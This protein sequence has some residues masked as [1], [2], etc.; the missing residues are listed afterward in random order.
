MRKMI[1][2]FL[3]CFFPVT[4][5]VLA[6]SDADRIKALEDKVE[7]LT[8]QLGLDKVDSTEEASAPKMTLKEKYDEKI[9]KVKSKIPFEISGS[10]DVYVQTNF[11]GKQTNAV[12]HRAF[13]PKANSFELGMIN[14]IMKKKVKKVGFVADI[15][16]GPRAEAANNTIYS[17]TILAIK[18]LYMTYAPAD[19]VEFTLGNFSTFFGYELI[20]PQNNFNYSTSL[21]FENGPFYHTGFKA[22]FM[23]KKWN[24]LAGFFNDTDT[25]SD[26]DRNKYVG[27]QVGYT[28]DNGGVY[29]NFVGG[30]EPTTYMVNDST[31]A[32]VYKNYK[33]SYDI[34]GSIKL[35]KDK[36]GKLGVNAAYHQ[37][38]YKAMKEDKVT[39]NKFFTTYLYGQCDINER[40][41]IGARAGYFFNPD[42]VAP[43]V[44][45]PAKHFAD[46]TLTSHINIIGGLKLIP[47]YRIDFSTDKVFLDRKGGGSKIQNTLSLAAVYAF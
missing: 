4:Q 45:G 36:K 23:V 1:F 2:S 47:E 22:N 12:A 8:N 5:V 20:E 46:F 44:A 19:W 13:T 38:R 32:A 6:Q 26:N 40:A 39:R 3:V 30:N 43:Y 28:G 33:N 11:N 34:T 17:N 15:G 29:L 24:F 27:A 7:M 31:E 14:L 18:Q 16:F 21:A 41:S 10:V 35:G 37:F 25:K 42:G 9:E